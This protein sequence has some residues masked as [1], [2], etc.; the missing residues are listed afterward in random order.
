M[1]EP[2]V[3]GDRDAASWTPE[4]PSYLSF[5]GFLAFPPREGQPGLGLGEPQ[6][7]TQPLTGSVNLVSAVSVVPRTGLG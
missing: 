2:N 3:L 4:H 5:F 7:Q 6:I 1:V